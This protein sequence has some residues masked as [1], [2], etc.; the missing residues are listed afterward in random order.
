MTFREAHMR[1]CKSSLKTKQYSRK[2]VTQKDGAA[3]GTLV[4]VNQSRL[5]AMSELRA[6]KERSPVSMLFSCPS[7]FLP[8]FQKMAEP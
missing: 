3:Q 4:T 5:T 2:E 8:I 1:S 6:A 7:S